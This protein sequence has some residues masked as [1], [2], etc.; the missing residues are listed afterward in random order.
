MKKI[1]IFSLVLILALST[2]QA[3]TE[4]NRFE[5][6]SLMAIEARLEGQSFVLAL[7]SLECP[8][9]Y[10]ELAMLAEWQKQ[11]LSSHLVLVSTDSNASPDELTAT[12]ERFDFVQ[13]E[14]WVF[15]DHNAQ[16]LRYAI[17][18]LWRGELPR[19]YLYKANQSRRAVSGLLDADDL[20]WQ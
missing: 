7:W 13:A 4:L 1:N 14:Q 15:A 17:D 6:D 16:R 9:C 2:A 11:N 18:P 20:L 5:F 12:L 10:K 8:P 19:S 3:N